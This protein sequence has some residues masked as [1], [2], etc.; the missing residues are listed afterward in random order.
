MRLLEISVAVS[1]TGMFLQVS[2]TVVMGLGP[3][4]FALLFCDGYRPLTFHLPFWWCAAAPVQAR[5]PVL[6]QCEQVQNRMWSASI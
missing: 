1:E 3:P 6:R 4:I 5:C 2:G